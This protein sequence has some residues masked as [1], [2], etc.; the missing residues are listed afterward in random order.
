MRPLIEK[1]HV[2]LAMPPLYRLTSGGKSIYA[3]DDAHKDELLKTE[4]KNKKVEISRFKGLGEMPAAQL[5][6]TTMNPNSRTLL[7]VVLP[8]QVDEY[9][10]HVIAASTETDDLVERLMGRN[11][12][13][14]FKFI[15]ENAEFVQ[16]IDI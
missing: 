16:D 1:G 14:R 9:G 12:D 15:Q 7:R 10:G 8:C 5:K 13:E 6:E 3:R 4:F 2:F 11:A